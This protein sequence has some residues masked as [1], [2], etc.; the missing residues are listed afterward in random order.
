M[1][2]LAVFLFRISVIQPRETQV[3]RIEAANV[4]MPGIIRDINH[5][6]PVKAIEVA[7]KQIIKVA[8]KLEKPVILPPIG[9]D[10]VSLQIEMRTE[11]ILFPFAWSIDRLIDGKID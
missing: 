9:D 6:K 8:E 7:K 10:P 2:C 5:E 1:V 11:R 4:A 3:E